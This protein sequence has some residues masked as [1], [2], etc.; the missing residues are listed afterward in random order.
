MEEMIN[1][2]GDIIEV[3]VYREF[4]QAIQHFKYKRLEQLE[5]RKKMKTNATI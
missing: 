5:S 3:E 1:K 4:E 2:E